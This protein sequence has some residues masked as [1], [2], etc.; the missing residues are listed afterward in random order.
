MKIALRESMVPGAALGEQLI[1]L[2]GV[3]IEGIELHG[4]A[5]DLA[6]DE[7]R[8]LFA[9][10][11]VTVASIDGGV[12]LLHPDPRE[13]QT[14]KERIRRRLALAGALGASGVLIVPQ[15][16]RGPRLPD[17]SPLKTAAELERELL[18]AQLREL[19]PAARAAGVPL[20]LEPL[21]RYEAYLVNRVDQGVAIAEAVGG[22]TGVMAD[23]FHMGIEEADI[24]AAI[25]AAGPCIV[26]VHLADSNRLQ[27]GRGHLDF[28]PGF[29]A[30]K[31]IGYDRFLG[32]ECRLDGP[33]T[34]V[35]PATARLLRDLWSAA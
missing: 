3:G 22:D 17:L 27:P 4:P 21:N 7:L 28:R 25:R 9:A 10:S 2:E 24:A 35:V 29:A 16:G 19:L 5:L 31:A 1:W 23:F 30:L 8:A 6:D 32:I 33:P 15:F 34:E 11:P 20:F 13:R 26:H 14:A 12:G 18:V